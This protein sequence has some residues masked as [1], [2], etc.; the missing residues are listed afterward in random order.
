VG[1]LFT[2]G[3]VSARARRALDTLRDRPLNFDLARREEFTRANGWQIDEWRR[4][5]PPEPPGPPLPDGSWAACKEV[6]ATYSFADPRIVR[7]V[8][9]PDT[10]LEDRELLLEGRFYGLR[11]LMG[12]RV[13][14]VT[15]TAT[16]VDG[17]QVRV[18]GW[19]YQTLQGHLEMGQMDYEVWKWTDTGA[20]ELRI[21][22]FSKPA[23]IRNPIV[24]LGFRL[25]G[26]SM[27][28]RFA[29]RALVRVDQQVCERL[30]G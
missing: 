19:N 25:F 4:T 16:Q 6:L 7:A 12:L 9:R 3:R 11:F 30:S 2:T 14:T 20:V 27:Q 18:W 21:D 15:D 5:L 8:Y 1:E 23:E 13:G 22:A 17:Q 24:R 26:R 29:R 10:P 28:R